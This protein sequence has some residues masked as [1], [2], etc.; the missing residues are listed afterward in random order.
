MHCKLPGLLKDE[1]ANTEIKEGIYCLF[2][3]ALTVKK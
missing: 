2:L 1:L 3:H